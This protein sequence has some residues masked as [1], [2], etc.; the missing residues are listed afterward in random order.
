MILRNPAT[1]PPGQAE[2]VVTVSGVPKTHD[3]IIY[4]RANDDD[5]DEV[6]FW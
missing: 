1:V 2:I 5:E 4:P 6:F 3:V